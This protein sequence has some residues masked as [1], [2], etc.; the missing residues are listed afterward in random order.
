LSLKGIN[1][2]RLSNMKA[3]L[4]KL[5]LDMANEIEVNNPEEVK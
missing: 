5:Q 2:K 4:E 1:S 3:Y